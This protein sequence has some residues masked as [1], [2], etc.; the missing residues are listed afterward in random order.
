MSKKTAKSTVHYFY[1]NGIDVDEKE[2]AQ[3]IK[4]TIREMKLDV[5]AYNQRINNILKTIDI[6]N[7]VSISFA[8]CGA[9]YINID[10]VRYLEE[11]IKNTNIKDAKGI[12]RSYYIVAIKFEKMVEKLINI[13][14]CD[15]G[16]AGF[17]ENSSYNIDYIPRKVKV[18][19]PRTKVY[20]GKGCGRFAEGGV[21]KATSKK[22][23]GN[24]G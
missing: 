5:R 7:R 6:L 13:L 20:R 16:A 14:D 3:D 18:K 19:T 24:R 2:A 23:R 9:S 15:S 12:L 17:L 10:N 22:G 11:S 8:K 4:K 1:K 21:R